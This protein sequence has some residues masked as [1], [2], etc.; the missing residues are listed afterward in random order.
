MCVCTAVKLMKFKPSVSKQSK[1]QLFKFSGWFFSV[2]L[3]TK[4]NYVRKFNSEFY[5]SKD[6]FQ[7]FQMPFSYSSWGWKWAYSLSTVYR[8][9]CVCR[10]VDA[11]SVFFYLAVVCC[12]INH[13]P[14]SD[15]DKSETMKCV[16]IF[17]F[18]IFCIIC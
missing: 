1:C 15:D 5:W 16:N 18:M 13:L 14:T 2:V 6:H 12:Y 11:S 4:I 7:S 9:M 8:C 3:C 17:C 10:M